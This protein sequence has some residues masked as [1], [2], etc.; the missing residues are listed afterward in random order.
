MTWMVWSCHGS[1]TIWTA[2]NRLAT[3]TI[4][5]RTYEYLT[6]ISQTRSVVIPSIPQPYDGGVSFTRVAMTVLPVVHRTYPLRSV[7][8]QS[9]GVVAGI[10]N[11][12]S[13]FFPAKEP[14]SSR[15][16]YR[17]RLP[18]RI[19]ARCVPGHGIYFFFFMRAWEET[20]ARE[21]AVNP[22][23]VGKEKIA[24]DIDI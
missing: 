17:M 5:S 23:M 15:S 14:G 16:K 24:N 10:C 4:P 7:G 2:I 9:C 18:L 6:N 3:T 22:E 11:G 1:S 21:P 8:F 20:G 19:T 12:Q 13:C